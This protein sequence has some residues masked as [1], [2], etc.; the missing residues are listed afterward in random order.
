MRRADDFN[1]KDMKA[2]KAVLDHIL[3]LKEQRSATFKREEIK[4][5]KMENELSRIN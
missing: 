3:S 2:L 5:K 4:T 1:Q